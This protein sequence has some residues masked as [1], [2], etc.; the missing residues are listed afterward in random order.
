MARGSALL[1]GS[2]LP[3]SRIVSERQAGLPRRFMPE[4]ATGREIV[5]LGEARPA[6][7]YPGRSIFF[8]PF[9]MAGL[10]P[11]F[12]SFFMDVLEF[13]DLQM[14]HLTPNA[15]MTL[16]IFAHLCEMFIGVRPSLR[17]FRWFFT[18]QSVSPP[19]VVGGCYFLPRG[20]VLN[21]YIPC[22]LRK[23]WDD[24]KSDWFY[25]PL[26]DETHLRLP[27]Q[28]PVQASSWRAPVDLG[29]GYDAVFDRLAGL[30]SQGL[31]GAMVYGD[32]LRRRIA[33]LQRRARATWEYI[34]PEDYMRTH[35]G[36][37]WDWAPEDFKI[38]IQR[39]LNLNSV[40][41]SLI[42]HGILP[43]CSDPD[44]VSILTIMTAVGAS[45][46]QAPKGHG[47][48][49]GSRRG[50]QSTPGGGRAS[51]PRVGG[52][53]SNRPTDARGKRK[54]GGTPPPSP[55]RGGGAARASSRRPEGAAPTSQPE[56]ER[57]K[58][59]L[60]KM[61]GTE[62]SQGNLISPPRWSFNRPPRSDVPSRPSRHPKSGQS[63]AEDPAAAEERRRESDRREAADRLREAEEAAREAARARQAEDTAREEAA[64]ARQAEEAAREEAARA[65]QTEAMAS[66]EA[67]HDK[68]AGASLGP[69]PSGDAQA[70]A[71]GAARD[72]AAGRS[73]GPAPSGDAQDQTGPGDIPE[74]S[75]SSG[76]PSRVA[77]SPRRLFSSSS[78]APLSAEPL[79]Q[80][81]AAAN[82]AVLDG[83]SAQVE[84]LR[85]E[86]AELEAAWAR[87]EEG[88]RS[89]DAMVKVGR[90]AHR[91]HISELE[92][93]KAALA[94]IAREVEE[95]REAALIAT[96]AMI[97]AQDSLRLQH[98][99]WEAEL[100]RKL[101]AAQGVLDAAAA[102][103]QRATE[104]EAASRWREEALEA[105][106]MALED[107]AGAVETSLADREAAAAIR[108]A[109][110]AAHEAACAE[111]ESALRLREDALAER[112]RALEESEA[113]TQR[114]ADS[115]SLREAAQEE[116]AHR[117]LE[118]VRA[119]RA[120]LE[121]RAA[122]LEARE[123]ELDARERSGGAATGESDLVAR[124]A[125]A[126]HTVAD[127][128]RA[129]DSSTGEAEALRLSG[130][131]GP[132]MLWDA[133]FRLDRAGREAGLWKGQTISR[134]T[135][136][137]GLAP[138]L[139]RMA[140]AVQQ[141]PEEL[142][143]TIKSSSRDLAQGAVELVL[144]SY[145]ARDPGFSP[146]MALEEFPPGTEDD[147]RARVRDA[148]NHVVQSFEGSAPRLAFAP[149]SDEEGDA[150]GEDDGGDE[151]SDP[152]ALE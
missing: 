59:R 16:A 25:T 121:Q 94:E 92:A 84:A 146:W 122:N 9:A 30:R 71:S 15:V 77:F 11:P 106:A 42:P 86:R 123:K 78:A 64:R 31:T 27:S 21:R 75:A 101:D 66:F 55:P 22:V 130:E 125:A 118:C 35:Q 36:V 108:E 70:T 26:A 103:E 12:S 45:E 39:V 68:A 95:E 131:I 52:S 145:Q 41:A 143:K 117:N 38:L 85:A 51:G 105:R 91:R 3:P 40:E 58:K 134:S 119:E 74:L 60:R 120:A 57:K 49:G 139:R 150:S 124:L 107:H 32:Y 102:R 73:P 99:S 17:L 5:M 113:A 93:R 114:L 80:S 87:V 89:V 129:L 137:E 111:E 127:M 126:E 47:G 6:P 76:G 10:V 63:E 53:G 132:G 23:K 112:E 7:D 34:G 144:A 149:S 97:E 116:Q 43:L 33:P 82:T 19:S 29:D 48:A 115:L 133:V 109:T 142:E 61:G 79:L 90:K 4:S 98:G 128:Q 141:L 24:W 88:R 147:A 28:P 56:G 54:L 151:A 2:V 20:P 138:H 110:L 65:R 135:N 50:D 83:F 104:A 8:L 100:K 140:W 81:L 18:V 14:A 96:T 148:A 72:E 152:G 62:L 1:D 37:R 67:A 44:R 13:Y 136:L 69:T 46:E